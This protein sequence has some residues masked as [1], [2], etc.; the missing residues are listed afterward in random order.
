MSDIQARSGSSTKKSVFDRLLAPGGGARGGTDLLAT[1][2]NLQF[3]SQ[4]G[5]NEFNQFI[6]FTTYQTEGA[7][8]SQGRRR[9]LREIPDQIDATREENA[10]LV[11]EELENRAL[12]SQSNLLAGNALDRVFGAGAGNRMIAREAAQIAN[13]REE[14]GRITRESQEEVDK[15]TTEGQDILRDRRNDAVNTQLDALFNIGDNTASEQFI[16]DRS[17]NTIQQ[18]EMLGL[19]VANRSD[20]DATGRLRIGSATQKSDTNIALYIPNKLVNTGSIGYNGV[21]F[22]LLQ[23]AQGVGSE[24][25]A[26]ANNIMSGEIM[27]AGDDVAAA[28]GAVGGLGVRAAAR[29]VDDLA[30]IVGVPLNAAEGLQQVTGLAI[31]PRQQQVFQGVQ[32]RGFDFTFSFAPKNQKEAIQVSKIIRAFRAAAHPSISNN[33][34]LNIPD[35]FEIR[36]Y[37][38][39]EDGVVAENLFLNKIGRCALTNVSVDYTPNGINATF[40][41]GSPVRTSMTLQFAELRPLTRD[42][43]E[44][45]Y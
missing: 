43:I 45:G 14:L 15:L 34:F 10:R 20:S 24:L 25:I 16:N 9:R 40:E 23:A 31:N 27:K 42:D 11:A 33:A 12:Q 44:E 5:E 4:L 6:L 19:D 3:P 39:H 21:N 41:D 2:T 1:D 29:I 38:I 13:T 17:F 35:E 22:E 7:Q 37:K 30:G 18:A 8:V 32:S 26:A 28:L 36:Y